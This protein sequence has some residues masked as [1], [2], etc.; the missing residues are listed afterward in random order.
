MHSVNELNRAFI[1]ELRSLSKNSDRQALAVLRRS[2]KQPPGEDFSVYRYIGK[3]IADDNRW[4][5]W[6]FSLL[7]GLFALAPSASESAPPFSL[8]KSLV[9]YCEEHPGAKNG[10]ERRLTALL[11][12]HKDDMPEHLRHVITLLAAARQEIDW[13]TLLRDLGGWH[14][15]RRW[16]QR[17]W[18]KDFWG[19]LAEKG[20]EKEN[21][22]N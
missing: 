19:G 16:V 7:A 20:E 21:E 15:E 22:S 6:S 3:Y 10:V 11:N 5:E 9:S 18:A 4:R 12:A 2:L 1:S 17:A 14:S 8:G 13:A